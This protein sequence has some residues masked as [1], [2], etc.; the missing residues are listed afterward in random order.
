M[1][2]YEINNSIQELF[3]RSIDPET[4]EV[5]D[6]FEADLESLSLAREEKVENIACLIK[7]LNADA[8]AIKA[9]AE[10][11][12]AE[13]KNLLDRAK[14]S[15]NRAKSLESYLAY[16]LGG[17]EFKTPKVAI[18]FRKSSSVEV[19]PLALVDIPDRYL[20]FKDP[21]PNKTEI[22]KALL[23]GEEIPGCRIVE[24]INMQ[25]K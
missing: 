15:E 21:E 18:S 23:A 20:R 1:K 11:L 12:K 10:I 7:N 22:K 8:A 5:A 25:I 14:A 2:L 6:G 24:T 9:Q 17:N 13:V 19:D 3:I 16:N 4:G